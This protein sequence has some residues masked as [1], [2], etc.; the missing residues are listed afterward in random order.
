MH[1]IITK[2]KTGKLY[3]KCGDKFID[4]SDTHYVCSEGHVLF[5]MKKKVNGKKRNPS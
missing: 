1:V 4:I 2:I 3:E 5:N